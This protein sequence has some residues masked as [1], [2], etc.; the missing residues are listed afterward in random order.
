MR[1]RRKALGL[2]LL[3]WLPMTV[4][5]GREN[6]W[7]LR[8]P[9]STYGHLRVVQWNVYWGKL[10][11]EKIVSELQKEQADIHILNEVPKDFDATT[12]AGQLGP[13]FSATH[14]GTMAA[15][16]RGRIV[17]GEWVINRVELKICQLDCLVRGDTLRI[18]I[19]DAPA[20][21]WIHRHPQLLE[22]ME[23]IRSRSPDLVL[24]DF[25]APRLSVAFQS[26]PPGYSHAYDV[27]GSGWS[28]TW[29]SP[30]PIF[31]LDQCLVGP[32]IAP[33]E[34]FIISTSMSDHRRQVLEFDRTDS[35][36]PDT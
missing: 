16:V 24:G 17:A 19:A 5:I 8:A 29:P 3:A 32:R 21:L 27:A 2:F 20:S 11:W 35:L 30:F 9:L 25:N 33:L 4:L 7:E 36:R 12:Y 1:R 26:L 22:C 10:G 14:L 6:R 15:A 34:Y 18:F 31:A 28:Y 23:A 13:D